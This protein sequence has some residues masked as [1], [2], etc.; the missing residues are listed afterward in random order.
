MR[1]DPQERMNRQ[2][3][4][5]IKNAYG[6]TKNNDWLAYHFRA[7]WNVEAELKLSF[8]N[9][10][11]QNGPIPLRLGLAIGFALARGVLADVM[12]AEA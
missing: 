8:P 7:K 4:K 3:A 11:Y 10:Q 9:T 1:R 5:T 2:K 6:Q 12:H